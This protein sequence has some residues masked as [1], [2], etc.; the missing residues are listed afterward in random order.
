MVVEMDMEM[1]GHVCQSC[2]VPM[3]EEDMS[4]G[5]ERGEFC[6]FCMVHD[7]F[8]SDRDAV[9]NKIADKIVEE[10]GKSREEA[11]KD[12]EDTMSKLKRWQ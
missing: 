8:V 9:K 11:L 6:H 10:T 3:S 2:G 5:S 7:E 4:D 12:A 1:E